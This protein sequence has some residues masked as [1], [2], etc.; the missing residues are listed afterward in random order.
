MPH[1][2][3]RTYPTLNGKKGVLP[4]ILRASKRTGKPLRY[5]RCGECKGYHM[6]SEARR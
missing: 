4:A 1:K 2:P 5:Y 3:K 6:T